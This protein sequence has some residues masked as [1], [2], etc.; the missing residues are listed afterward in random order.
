MEMLGSDELWL[1]VRS[2][3]GR[4]VCTIERREANAVVQVTGSEVKLAK[5]GKPRTSVLRSDVENTY[6]YLVR[7]GEVTK[8]D[9]TKVAG[10]RPHGRVGR[11]VLAILRD[12]VPEQ[13]EEV[14]RGSGVRLSGIALKGGGGC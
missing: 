5:G 1:R 10:H 6:Q 2:L 11:V 13:V 14:R 8:E 9:F 12:A 3:E 4:T 7:N